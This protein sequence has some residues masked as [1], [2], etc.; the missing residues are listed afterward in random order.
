MA[1]LI[2]VGTTETTFAT[3]EFTVAAGSQVSLL[4]KGAADGGIPDVEFEIARKTF[5][6]QYITLMTLDAGNMLEKGVVNGG[7]A[8]ITYAARR[9]ASAIAAGLDYA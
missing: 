5:G 3:G 1:E 8:P 6:G 4:I 2:A 7:S 9:K